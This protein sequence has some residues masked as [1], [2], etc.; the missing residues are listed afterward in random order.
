MSY[1]VVYRLAPR[2]CVSRP[3]SQASRTAPH[4]STD[5]S[6]DPITTHARTHTHAAAAKG[7]GLMAECAAWFHPEHF[8]AVVEELAS[9]VRTGPRPVGSKCILVDPSSFTRCHC[10]HDMT[11]TTPA[12]TRTG[13]VRL[14]PLPPHTGRRPPAGPPP[15][16]EE[17]R[18]EEPPHRG[19]DAGNGNGT[20]RVVRTY[21]LART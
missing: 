17:D 15:R 16:A 12:H 20:Y 2:V 8:A 3:T 19:R 11:S 13:P 10:R 21:V 18:R 14:P 5:P 7:K 4:P 6:T 9:L 1:C